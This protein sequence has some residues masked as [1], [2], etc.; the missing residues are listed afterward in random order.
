MINQITAI[1]FSWLS[2]SFGNLANFQM[3][4]ELPSFTRVIFQLIFLMCC[5]DFVIYYLHRLLHHRLIYKHIHKKHHEFTAPISILA[6]YNHPIEN[7]S[8][9]I[10]P[11]SFVLPLIKPHILTAMLWMTVV[12]ITALNDH[13]GFHL[14]FLHSPELHD[15]HHLT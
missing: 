8:N 7:L 9:N 14:P 13:S 4:P 11:A 12:I 1:A 15:F 2:F 6:M 10:F 5:Q 3:T